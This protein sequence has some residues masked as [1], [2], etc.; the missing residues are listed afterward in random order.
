MGAQCGIADMHP[1]APSAKWEDH[2]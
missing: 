1:H 2:I